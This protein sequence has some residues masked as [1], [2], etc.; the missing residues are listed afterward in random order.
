MIGN[1]LNPS[2]ALYTGTFIGYIGIDYAEPTS[3]GYQLTAGIS[4]IIQ[5]SLVNAVLHL[6][7]DMGFSL[8]A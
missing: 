2:P 5:G 7:Q 3:I 8:I 1:V 6:V 4:L